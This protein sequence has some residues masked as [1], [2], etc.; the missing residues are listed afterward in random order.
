[1][2]NCQQQQR[3]RRRQRQLQSRAGGSEAKAE[4]GQRWTCFGTWT[5]RR[6]AR[7]WCSSLCRLSAVC[8]ALLKGAGA[9]AGVV[10]SRFCPSPVTRG[11]VCKR[12]RTALG[13]CCLS[14]GPRGCEREGRIPCGRRRRWY[15]RLCRKDPGRSRFPHLM[16]KYFGPFPP[17][18]G[19]WAAERYRPEGGWRCSPKP[20]PPSALPLE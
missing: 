20:S 15:P 1:M 18:S 4:N 19:V 13:L 17:A 9:H 16:I 3:R 2:R 6:A 12:G 7:P 14:R 5:R 11:L 8:F 10:Q